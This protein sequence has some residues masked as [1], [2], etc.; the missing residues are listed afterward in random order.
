MLIFVQLFFHRA[1]MS[2]IGNMK[3]IP[4]HKFTISNIEIEYRDAYRLSASCRI[5]GQKNIANFFFI[6]TEL[7]F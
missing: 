1:H 4:V 7:S 6:H 5:S 2:E 3:N